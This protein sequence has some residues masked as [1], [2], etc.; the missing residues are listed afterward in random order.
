MK[1]DFDLPRGGLVVEKGNRRKQDTQSVEKFGFHRS[2]TV[3]D[4]CVM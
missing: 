3:L 2:T 4:R 1:P